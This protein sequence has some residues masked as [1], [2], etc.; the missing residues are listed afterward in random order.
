MDLFAVCDLNLYC[1]YICYH[2][3]SY[4]VLA[5]LSS[6]PQSPS[7]PTSDIAVPPAKLFPTPTRR[8]T[9][10]R[11]IRV[12]RRFRPDVTPTASQASYNRHHDLVLV[13]SL[14]ALL[15]DSCHWNHRQCTNTPHATVSVCTARERIDYGYTAGNPEV[16]VPD[17]LSSADDIE[18]HMH[19]RSDQ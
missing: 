10:H 6:R 19:L 14:L 16:L 12:A 5:C 11:Y 9:H 17:L 4:I 18:Q 8:W 3:Y 2:P 1:R 7:L 15:L 13:V